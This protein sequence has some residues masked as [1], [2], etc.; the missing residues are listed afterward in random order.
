MLSASNRHMYIRNLTHPAASID[1]V[2]TSFLTRNAAWY[3]TLV[4]LKQQGM[5]PESVSSVGWRACKLEQGVDEASG[6]L[7]RC[8]AFCPQQRQ[9]GRQIWPTPVHGWPTGPSF[10]PLSDTE[11]VGSKIYC[12]RNTTTAQTSRHNQPGAG[13]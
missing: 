1:G 12:P 10:L 8:L 5:G 2:R 4:T 9:C 13:R 7:P 3:L 11:C 6:L